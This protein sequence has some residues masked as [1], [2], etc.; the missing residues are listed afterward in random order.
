MYLSWEKAPGQRSVKTAF[1]GDFQL[2]F[3]NIS[4]DGLPNFAHIRW[5]FW[6][7]PRAGLCESHSSNLT[8]HD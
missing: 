2:Y 3:P 4:F 5:Q 6:A 7:D 8:Y 1:P